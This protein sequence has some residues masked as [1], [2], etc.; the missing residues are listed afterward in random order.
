MYTHTEKHRRLEQYLLAGPDMIDGLK[1]H[2]E[3]MVRRYSTP[4]TH[5]RTEQYFMVGLDMVD[6]VKAHAEKMA[7]S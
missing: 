1:A 4:H 7:R 3:K 2:A 6:G 5:R